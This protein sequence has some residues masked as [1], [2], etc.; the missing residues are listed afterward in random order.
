MDPMPPD[1]CCYEGARAAI[2]AMYP[3]TFAMI[4]AGVPEL[5]RNSL[6]GA[7]HAMIDAALRD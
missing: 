4:E 6:A 3:A 7:F 5:Q 2:E 1:C